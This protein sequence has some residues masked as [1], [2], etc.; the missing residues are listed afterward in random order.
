MQFRKRAFDEM[1]RG[2]GRIYL[3]IRA[4]AIAFNGV[5]PLGNLPLEFDFGQRHGLW[6]IHLHAVSRG[7]EVTNVDQA[8][9]RGR[10]ETRDGAASG[11]ERKVIARPLVEPTWR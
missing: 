4:R 7:L 5:A 3:E 9:Q 2:T 8:G 6:Q 11:V 10:P 1:K